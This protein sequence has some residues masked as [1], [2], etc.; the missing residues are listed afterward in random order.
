MLEWFGLDKNLID[1]LFA[2]KEITMTSAEIE[3]VFEDDVN[4]PYS[5]N[6]ELLMG[7]LNAEFD[8]KYIFMKH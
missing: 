3:E 1:E 6:L 4:L 2:G 7:K 5:F 8:W